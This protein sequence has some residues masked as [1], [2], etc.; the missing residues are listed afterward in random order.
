M[1]SENSCLS[2]FITALAAEK[3]ASP[4]TVEA[5]ERDVGAFLDFLEGAEARPSH[6]AAWATHLATQNYAASSIRRALMALRVYFRFLK[7]EGVLAENMALYIETP[8]IWQRIPAILTL[9]EVERLFAQPDTSIA[10]GARDRAILELLYASGLRV[11]ELCSLSLYSVGER[12][13][14]VMGKGRKERIVPVGAPALAALDH[15]LLNFRGEPDTLLIK[16]V[17]PKEKSLKDDFILKIAEKSPQL[18]GGE[19]IGQKDVAGTIAREHLVGVIARLPI[20]Q[21]HNLG[22]EVGQ[23]LLLAAGLPKDMVHLTLRPLKPNK[24]NRNNLRP[25]MNQLKERVLRIG[26]RLP[27]NNLPCLPLHSPPLPVNPFAV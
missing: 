6:F 26:P 13:V 1:P 24:L 7:R 5:Y 2:D 25:L 9:E 16:R 11:S 18:P 19:L 3:G 21:C 4:H 17:N 8:K 23:K 27:P 20:G 22:E 14:R 10:K 15:Y 12:T